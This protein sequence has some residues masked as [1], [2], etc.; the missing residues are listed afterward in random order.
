M[1]VLDSYIYLMVE[2]DGRAFKIGTSLNPIARSYQLHN[3]ID[4]D[5]SLQFKFQ[6]RQAAKAERMLHFLFRTNRQTREKADGSTEWFDI[7]CLALTKQF[8]WTMRDL[9]GW[10]E[11]S[12]L[13][14]VGKA[15]GATPAAVALTDAAARKA[16][17][18]AQLEVERQKVMERTVRRKLEAAR[19]AAERIKALTDRGLSAGQVKG[20][21]SEKGRKRRPEPVRT[22]RLGHLHPLSV[23]RDP[24]RWI[25]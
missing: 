14:P 9:V 11:W 8:L 2:S 10:V 6:G 4:Y 22:I 19:L 16:L 7:D 13:N 21:K 12:A 5:R 24:K 20:T 17:H 18:E 15:P 1:A 3:V 23:Q 25:T